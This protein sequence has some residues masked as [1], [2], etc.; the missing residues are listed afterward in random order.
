M[1]NEFPPDFENEI[2][3]IS[4]DFDGVIHNNDRGWYDG[5]CYGDPIPGAL[6]AIRELS[7]S[8]NIIITT[9]KARSDRPLVNGKTG[10]ELVKDW[11]RKYDIINHIKEITAEKPRAC[12]Y[13]DDKGYRFE[14]WR[15]TMFFLVN[16]REN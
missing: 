15:D 4:I 16:I 7:R 10:I 11:C 14:N 2:N 1:D 3:N 13:I 6:D 9:A 12:V 5:T 8:F